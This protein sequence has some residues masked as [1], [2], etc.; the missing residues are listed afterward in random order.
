M[1]TA[2][3][4]AVMLEK[5][6]FQF[7]FIVAGFLCLSIF[8][9]GFLSL[10]GINSGFFHLIVSILTLG[11]IYGFAKSKFIYFTKKKK[12]YIV[13][14]KGKKGKREKGKKKGNGGRS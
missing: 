8:I 1:I 9:R 10:I 5:N 3:E 4:S 7:L 11:G 13:A 2:T 14:I 6:I 12:S